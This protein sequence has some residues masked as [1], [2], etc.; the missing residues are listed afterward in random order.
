MALVVDWGAVIVNMGV[1]ALAFLTVFLF[2]SMWRMLRDNERK[3]NELDKAIALHLK[4][5]PDCKTCR[6]QNLE[7]MDHEDHRIDT[8]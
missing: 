6:N 1:G 4:Q 7:T 8:A 3:L 2:N 5:H